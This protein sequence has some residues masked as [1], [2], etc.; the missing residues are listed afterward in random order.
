MKERPIVLVHGYSD[1]GESFKRWCFHL[2]NAG[3]DMTELNVCSYESLT[4]EITIKDVGEAFDR[5]L[6]LQAHIH[7]DKP[8]DAIVHS[9]GM[10]VV[11]AWLTGRDRSRISRL[12]HL[13]ALAPATFGSPLAHKGRSTLGSIFKGNRAVGPDF[14]EAGDLILDGLELASRFQWELTHQD[15]FNATPVYGDG[16]DTPWV[17]TFCG[18]EAYSGLRRLVNAPGTDGTVRW[19][20]CSLACRKVDMDL[21]RPSTE[22]RVLFAPWKHVAAP[23]VFVKGLTHATIMSDPPPELVQLVASA[24]EVNSNGDYA[25]WQTRAATVSQEHDL[26]T[27]GRAYQQFVVRAIDERGDPVSDYHVEVFTRGGDPKGREKII[28]AFDDDPHP[29]AGDKSLRCFHVNLANVV[30]EELKDLWL[31][32]IVS[33]GSKL[34]AYQGYGTSAGARHQVREVGGE[35]SDD[36]GSTELEIDLTEHLPQGPGTDFF[37]PF[38]TTLVQIRFNREPFPFEGATK[39]LRWLPENPSGG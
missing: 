23:T 7:P 34:V 29:Y 4:N 27:S 3:Y 30:R 36:E 31:R 37:V 22:R 15:V 35:S 32:V 9:T 20:G 21:T 11:R 24:F 38:T 6:K 1:K 39:L 10:L 2:T 18:T 28:E 19:A 12:K 5:A 26:V 16:P 33:S 17:F 14:L 13:V 25:A 8:F